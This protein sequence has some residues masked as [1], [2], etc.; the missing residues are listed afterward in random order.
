MRKFATDGNEPISTSTTICAGFILI[1]Q[2]GLFSIV[3]CKWRARTQANCTWE[4]SIIYFRQTECEHNYS[5]TTE[6][7][8]YHAVNAVMEPWKIVK[9]KLN[10]N[11]PFT[12]KPTAFAEAIAEAANIAPKPPVALP[13][14]AFGPV[15]FAAAVVV[16]VTATN[17]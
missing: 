9:P 14:P 7:A 4:N 5:A 12:T 1:D 3:C 2:T 10:D 16:A 6:Q 13:E 17:Q 11:T 8:G 15:I